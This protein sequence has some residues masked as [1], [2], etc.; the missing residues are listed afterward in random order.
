MQYTAL[1]HQ[2]GSSWNAYAPDLPGCVAAAP[3]RE[4]VEELI[5]E[6]IPLHWNRSGI[7]VAVSPSTRRLQFGMRV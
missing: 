7:A 4:I 5:C 3:S 1:I 6:A 2:A